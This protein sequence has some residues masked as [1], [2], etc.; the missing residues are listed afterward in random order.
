MIISDQKIAP[1]YDNLLNQSF[2]HFIILFYILFFYF[3]TFFGVI[4]T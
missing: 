4:Y 3:F 1:K 2:I